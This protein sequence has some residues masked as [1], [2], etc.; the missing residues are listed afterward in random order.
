[1]REV[2]RVHPASSSEP[3]HHLDSMFHLQLLTFARLVMGGSGHKMPSTHPNGMWLVR[4]RVNASSNVPSDASL[5]HSNRVSSAWVDQVAPSSELDL[6]PPR[7][8]TSPLGVATRKS[9]LWWT[10]LTFPP[11]SHTSYMGMSSAT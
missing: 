9:Q 3:P 2:W 11:S 4:H 7:G 5:S 1:M 6:L 10:V 8:V